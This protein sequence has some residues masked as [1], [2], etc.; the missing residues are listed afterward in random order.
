MGKNTRWTPKAIAR[1]AKKYKT[2]QAF[3]RGSYNAYQA[4]ARFGIKNELALAIEVIDF[5][6]IGLDHA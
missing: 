4:A 6:D 5:C 3:K 2:R 1:E